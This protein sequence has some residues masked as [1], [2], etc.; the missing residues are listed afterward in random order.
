MWPGTTNQLKIYRAGESQLR[1]C[2]HIN[3]FPNL[4]RHLQLLGQESDVFGMVFQWVRMSTVVNSSS[5]VNLL[6]MLKSA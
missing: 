2:L 6:G 3:D 1:A 4:L 5:G